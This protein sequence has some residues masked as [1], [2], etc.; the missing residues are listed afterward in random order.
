MDVMKFLEPITYHNL[1]ELRPGEWIWDNDE[2]EKSEHSRSLFSPN[3][4]EPIGFRQIHI[5]DV[6]GYKQYGGALWMLSNWSRGYY[7]WDYFSEGRYYRFKRKEEL[8]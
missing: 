1:D 4:L 6:K 3:I 7:K 8:I 5:L 2:V